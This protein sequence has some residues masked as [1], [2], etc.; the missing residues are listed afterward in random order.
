V[1]PRF[2]RETAVVA[3]RAPVRFVFGEYTKEL[4]EAR[5][6]IG[7]LGRDLEP[8]ELARIELTV[9]PGTDI[10]R[11]Q[12]FEEQDLVVSTAVETTMRALGRDPER[13]P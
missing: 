5:M 7:E 1:S 13:T 12:T 2:R 3:K 4:P 10:H 11:F 9:I 8:A 6:L